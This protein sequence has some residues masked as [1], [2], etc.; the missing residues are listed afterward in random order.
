MSSPE[1]TFQGF[2][3]LDCRTPQFADP[4]NN[5]YKPQS[6]KVDDDDPK[7]SLEQIERQRKIYEEQAGEDVPLGTVTVEDDPEHKTVDEFWFQTGDSD[8]G[9]GKEDDD[10]YVSDAQHEED[11]SAGAYD[12][13]IMSSIIN[14]ESLPELRHRY[15]KRA[16]NVWRRYE[17]L[18]KDGML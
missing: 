14:G 5:T 1:E 15:G 6:I 9:D 12:D 17:K 3:G 4:P 11:I 16:D 7:P 13:D 8:R 18:K 10:D 2:E